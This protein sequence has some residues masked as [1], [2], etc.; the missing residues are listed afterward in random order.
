MEGSHGSALIQPRWG[1][2]APAWRAERRQAWVQRVREYTL[3]LLAK[4]LTARAP[5]HFVGHARKHFCGARAQVWCCQHC[6][7][8][9][10]S[11]CDNSLR[12][13]VSLACSANDPTH[14]PRPNFAPSF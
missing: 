9:G 14:S 5:E 7:A 11:R 3:G 2:P 1:A 12:R 8:L 13:C 10:V 6:A 4:L